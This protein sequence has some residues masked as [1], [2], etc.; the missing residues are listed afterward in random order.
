MKWFITR[1]SV[2]LL[3]VVALPLGYFFIK[4]A[5]TLTENEVIVQRVFDKQLETI[6]FTV[7]Q[8]SENIINAWINQI[9]IPANYKGEIIQK[10]TNRLLENNK[11]IKKIIFYD[12]NSFSSIVA[13][14]QNQL[15][16]S[17]LSL[18]SESLINKLTEFS[19]NNYQRI[20][21]VRNNE[22]T[23]LYFL[24]KS[25]ENPVV[26]IICIHS[27]TF[28]D[29]NLNPG[30]QQISQDRFNISILDTIQNTS[31][32]KSDTIT[33][34]TDNVHKQN[35]WY[36][37]GYQISIELQSATIN[38]L[39]AQRSQLDNYIFIGLLLVVLIGITIV[40]ITIR[41]EVKVAEMKS[42]FVSNVS[43][44]IRTPLALISMYAETLLL[45]RV[46]NEKKV[47]EYLNI[48][49][50]ETT[51]LTAMV[52]RI[53]SFSKME[54]RKRIY[55]FNE[56]DLNELINTVVSTFEPHFKANNL[57]LNLEL[58][59]ISKVSADKDAVIEALINLIE[60]S[61]KYGQSDNKTLTIRTFEK[62]N[63]ITVEIEDNGIGISKKHV[64]HIFDK[65]YRITE[66]NIAHKA[67]GS[68]IGLNIV[69]QIM[70]SHEG[71]VKVKS[72]LGKGSCFSL[73][74]KNNTN[75]HG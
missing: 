3:I 8:N 74:F 63:T 27:K 25:D 32:F 53:L 43:H 47:D 69:Q 59:Q 9:D 60:N 36:I 56:I 40:I 16:S 31:Q 12:V 13:Y 44:E 18:P 68:G 1:I 46:K 24:L 10:V 72:E 48:I 2:V 30:I 20:E 17:Q 75:S 49:H 57:I 28:I 58:S 42:E 6:L 35:L 38:E 52:N 19:K 50:L 23:T 61:I 73:S 15:Q 34:Q 29:Y 39:V 21:A 5:S 66:G 37:P 7:N 45:K 11:A 70:K 71:T 62:T 26:G 64:K 14:S 67:K 65:F 54:K 41:K 4:E 33:T 51:R 22:Y 55:Q